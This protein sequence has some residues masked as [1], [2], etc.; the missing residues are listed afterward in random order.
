M[1]YLADA[2]SGAVRVKADFSVGKDYSLPRVGLKA[3]ISS[4]FGNV[5]WYGRGPMENYPDRKDCAFVGVYSLSVDEMA[6]KYVRAQSM[7]ER[8]DVRWLSMTDND[9]FGVRIS[10]K[11]NLFHFSAQHYTD[12]DL[13]NVV[14]GHELP[15][16]R[17]EETV[18]CLDAAMR[19]LGNASCG[20]GPLPEYEIARG[21]TWT[22]DFE[23][24][25]IFPLSF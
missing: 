22:L 23:I 2:E 25:P 17:K 6:E 9:D 15:A 8:C 7:G 24:T 13:W 11:G 3:L 10:T 18:L 1:T 19:G 5:T 20:Q 14:Y 21:C 16:I 4:R 12:Q